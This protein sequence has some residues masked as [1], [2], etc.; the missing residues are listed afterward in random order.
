M[1]VLLIRPNRNEADC[2]ALMGV[3]I[4]S[5]TDPYLDISQVENPEGAQT[6]LE[7]LQAPTEKWLVI[8]S[9]NALHYWQHQ[10]RPGAIEEA[11]SSTP[12]RFAALGTLTAEILSDIGGRDIVIPDTNTSVGLAD[13]IGQNE[14]QAVVLP[15]GSISMK[16]IPRTLIPRGFVVHEEVFY[17][18]QPTNKKPPT[19]GKLRENGIDAVLL[20]SPSAVRIFVD[21][22]P[23]LDDSV[24]LVCAGRT[25]ARQ[26]KKLGHEAQLVSPDPSPGSVARAL[27][28]FIQEHR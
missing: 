6:L 24:A 5:L 21:Q 7:A 9:H 19:A 10:L 17:H 15:S 23:Q 28:L 20:R 27:S 3:G 22:N 14:P 16:S 18:T 2:E 8:T 1:K 25:T 12:M 11:I 4:E 26:L 13:L